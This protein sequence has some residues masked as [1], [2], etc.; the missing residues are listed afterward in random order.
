[1][2]LESS[3]MNLDNSNYFKQINFSIFDHNWKLTLLGKVSEN[4]IEN[5]SIKFLITSALEEW[6]L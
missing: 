4:L 6:Q 5:Y 2:E 3:Y 1:M